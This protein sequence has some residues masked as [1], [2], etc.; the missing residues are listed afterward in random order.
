MTDAS[1]PVTTFAGYQQHPLSAPPVTSLHL[2]PSLSTSGS[3]DVDDDGEINCICAYQED[4]GS[5]IQCDICNKWQHVICY[6]PNEADVPG[7]N[8]KHYCI[9]CDPDRHNLDARKA[10]ERQR[11]ALNERSAAIG[12]LKRTASKT[13][14][15]KTKDASLLNGLSGDRH[16]HLHSRDRKSASPRDLPPPAKKP[17]TSHRASASVTHTRKRNGTVTHHSSSRSPDPP[18][19]PGPSIPWYTDDFRQAYDALQSHTETESNLLNNIAVT[20]SLSLWLADPDAVIKETGCPQSSIFK[21]WNGSIDEIPGRPATSIALGHDEGH[22][23]ETNLYPT[24][25]SLITEEQLGPGSFIGELKGHIGFKD[26]YRED[27]D[28]R[29]FT[30]RHPEPFVFFHQQ[31]PIYVDARQEGSMFRYVRRSCSPNA[32]LQTII[33][34][35]NEYHFCFM[36]TKEIMPGEEVTVPWQI[37]DSVKEKLATAINVTSG[38]LGQ[39]ARNYVSNWVSIVLANCGPCA[40]GGGDGCLMRRFDNRGGLAAPEAV[41]SSIKASKLRKKKIV[42]QI[43]PIDISHAS[44]SRSG[45]ETRKLDRDEDMTDSRSVSGSCRGGSVSRDITPNT[46]Y[47]ASAALPEMSERERKKLMREEEMF[48]KQ[49]AESGRPKKKRN[50]GGSNL[51]TPSVTTSVCM[52]RTCLRVAQANAW[53]QKQLGH[54]ANTPSSLKYVDAGTYSRPS[55]RPVNSRRG[56]KTGLATS[57]SLSKPSSTTSRTPKPSY[58]D[59]GIQCDMDEVEAAGKPAPIP[60]PQRR[61][62]SVTQRLLQR[63]ATN[64]FKR[65]AES[66]DSSKLS[67]TKEDTAMVDNSVTVSPMPV[68]APESP[69]VDDPTDVP[70]ADNEVANK[71][72]VPVVAEVSVE[73]TDT[74]M[75]EADAESSI[76]A[77]TSPRSRKSSVSPRG[78]SPVEAEAAPISYLPAEPP[79]PPWPQKALSSVPVKESTPPP[80]TA[81]RQPKHHRVNY[82][83]M[84]MPPP[85]L[86]PFNTQPSTSGTPQ[87]AGAVITPSIAQSPL[88]LTPGAQPFLFSPNVQAAVGG[89]GPARKKMSLSDYTKRSKARETEVG[90]EGSPASTSSAVVSSASADQALQGSAIESPRPANLT[91]EPTLSA[92]P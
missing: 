12:H 44:N 82:L 65:K 23:Y 22:P 71:D 58:V 13:H 41:S 83:H 67:E 78:G 27:P 31:L 53:Q 40:C 88:S 72:A 37:H 90:R 25:A 51:N 29:W 21:K 38:T 80:T 49:E 54:P 73:K 5:T 4:D 34:D 56:T 39:E 10:T 75:G 26:D 15:K 24:W 81:S 52:D 77:T 33:T 1:L 74:V 36:A 11:R 92:N 84:E 68:T 60:R 43:S 3:V 42:P 9:D 14:K 89:H 20:N 79:A 76:A 59:A 63:C 7:D 86:N 19:S 57:R 28:N 35:P 32:E 6:Y 48:R 85:P 8:D 62:I 50:S 30:L 46:H 16:T 64:N 69:R 17:K 66:E 91:P 55:G 18:V 2:G 45:S 47:S 61:V 87:T 70:M